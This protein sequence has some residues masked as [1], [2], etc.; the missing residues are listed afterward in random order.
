MTW[1]RRDRVSKMFA[2][3]YCN[4]IVIYYVSVLLAISYIFKNHHPIIGDQRKLSVRRIKLNPRDTR[5]HIEAAPSWREPL[6]T[7]LK[8][9]IYVGRFE[10]L[11]WTVESQMVPFCS[12]IVHLKPRV[13]MMPTFNIFMMK[14]PPETSIRHSVY[15][16]FLR[17]IHWWLMES[18]HKEAVILKAFPWH[19][20][21]VFCRIRHNICVTDY[22]ST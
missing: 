3:L 4:G 18:P 2:K 19:D 9:L 16:P 21:V 17:G 14:R 10:T 8:Y 7:G 1:R 13:V 11:L 12:T 5:I 15:W 6:F 22:G 20:S